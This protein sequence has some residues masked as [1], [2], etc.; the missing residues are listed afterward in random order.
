MRL[1]HVHRLYM[2]AQ[3]SSSNVQPVR[4]YNYGEFGVELR[5]DFT[6]GSSTSE[7]TLGVP[8]LSI[9]Q[10]NYYN[11]LYDHLANETK[12]V[13]SQTIYDDEYEEVIEANVTSSVMEITTTATPWW[14]V[15]IRFIVEAH[16]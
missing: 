10:I 7:F 9:N 12:F 4:T 8:G 2:R 16:D 15:P 11:V 1:I 6:G 13:Q 3:G 14:T 5:F